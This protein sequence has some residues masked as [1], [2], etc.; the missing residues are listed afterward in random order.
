MP[1]DGN[2]QGA[3]AA[4]SAHVF[5][6]VAPGRIATVVTHLEMFARPEPRPM[7]APAGMRVERVRDPEPEWYR[8]LYAA[9][10][11][12]WLWYTRLAMDDAALT[13]AIREPG[14]EV[15]R[16]VQGDREIGLLELDFRK[17]PDV[18]LLYFGVTAEAIGTG[19]AHMLM[20]AAQERA[21]RDGP[22][23]VWVH[24]CTLDH[25]RALGFYERAG[26]RAFKREI[27]VDDDPRLKG[28]L[29]RDAAAWYPIID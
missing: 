9:V 4:A 13:A 16:L 8:A 11:A 28:V 19:A 27:E 17:W 24:T 6:P 10:G 23:R 25:P 22:R 26:F 7:R 1:N 3:P 5:T 2:G 29:P 12:D 18:E 21:W 15:F 14:I 20:Q